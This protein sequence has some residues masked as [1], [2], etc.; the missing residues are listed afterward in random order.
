[1]PSQLFVISCT[2]RGNTNRTETHTHT[3]ETWFG[4]SS[5][6]QCASVMLCRWRRRG[7]RRRGAGRWAQAAL[8]TLPGWTG[9]D[10][11]GSWW[12]RGWVAGSRW[13]AAASG[14]PQ[15]CGGC[16]R[17]WSPSCCWGSRCCPPS[18][19]LRR[20]ETHTHTRDSER[21]FSP[22]GDLF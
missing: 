10:S 4:F 15:S 13:W 5:T 1:M 14:S 7:G 16:C 21:V 17:W 18:A 19:A 12:G 6:H 3:S 22:A 9:R 8:Q 20:R 2:R 11:T